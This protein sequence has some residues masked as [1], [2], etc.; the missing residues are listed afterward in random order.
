[1]SAHELA[2]LRATLE[3]RRKLL[4]KKKD[5]LSDLLWNVIPK[6]GGSGSLREIGN[7][8][9]LDED[10][11]DRRRHN[12]APFEQSPTAL[13]EETKRAASA[14]R[15]RSD[16]ITLLTSEESPWANLQLQRNGHG[17]SRVSCYSLS[18]TSPRA[19][20][21]STVQ[22]IDKEISILKELSHEHI[23]GF[24]DAYRCKNG[25]YLLTATPS[26]LSLESFIKRQRNS[27]CY[28]TLVR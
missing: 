20:K 4:R 25:L 1:M 8:P 23:A 13:G 14:S 27:E 15:R 6:L 22:G 18:L 16:I 24:V 7:L 11:I 21:L 19:F 28:Q 26:T 9:V 3:S 10:E 12:G 17:R 2:Q 5:L